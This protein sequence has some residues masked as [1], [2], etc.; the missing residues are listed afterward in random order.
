MYRPFQKEEEITELIEL[1]F[2]PNLKPEKLNELHDQILPV[3][4]KMMPYLESTEEARLMAE[5]AILASE[6]AAENLDPHGEQ[7]NAEEALE[8]I[9]QLSEYMHQDPDNL[10]ERKETSSVEKIYRPIQV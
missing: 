4:A 3:K 6:S 10:I 8:E 7:E 9:V 1:I 5:S 2:E